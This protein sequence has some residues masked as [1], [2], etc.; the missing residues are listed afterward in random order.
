MSYI[1]PHNVYKLKGFLDSPTL[2]DYFLMRE[3]DM[4]KAY[5]SLFFAENV[6]SPSLSERGWGEVIFIVLPQIFYYG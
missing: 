2:Y 5:P 6:Q 3:N 1:F 4:L